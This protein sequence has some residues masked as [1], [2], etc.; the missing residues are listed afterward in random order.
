MKITISID[1]ND[2]GHY[3]VTFRPRKP[4]VYKTLDEMVKDLVSLEICNVICCEE[5]DV[6]RN[7]ELEKRYKFFLGEMG[8]NPY[9]PEFD[10]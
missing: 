6:L 2:M 9:D 5:M 8:M 10:M 3:V 1:R 7:E 4:C